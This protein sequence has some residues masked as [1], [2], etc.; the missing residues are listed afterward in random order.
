MYT[1]RVRAKTPWGIYSPYSNEAEV[2]TLIPVELTSFEG[3]V[4]DGDVGLRWGTA[5]EINNLGF[6]IEKR[7]TSNVKRDNNWKKIGFV[8]GHG[9]TTE[10]QSYS[11]T[12]E[13]ILSGSYQYRLKQVDYDGSYEY[14]N[15]IEVKV[16]I[17]T[18]FLLEQNYPNP[19]NPTTKIRFSI[20]TSPQSPPYQGGEAKQ[21]W[22]VQLKIYD[23]LGNEIATLVNEEK[24]TGIYEVK[25]DA[26]G[27][28]SGM[29]FYKL[30]AGNFVETKKMLVIK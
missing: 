17:P 15:I 28:T 9:T 27:I 8:Q 22:F 11:F 10:P 18:E 7:Q 6:S 21:G 29:Y 4:V 26:T 3:N 12:D 20:P 19:F 5:T 24:K 14:S 16:R 23:V 30:Q 25:F 13:S 2:L 1:Y